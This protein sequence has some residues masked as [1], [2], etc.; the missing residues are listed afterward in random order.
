[1]MMG[2]NHDSLLGIS[3]QIGG[4]AVIVT[5]GGHCEFVEYAGTKPAPAADACVKLAIPC[6]YVLGRDQE[7]GFLFPERPDVIE[8]MSQFLGRE[9]LQPAGLL[10]DRD[11]RH[12]HHHSHHWWRH[13]HHHH[14]HGHDDHR[15]DG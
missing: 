9:V 6:T 4:C 15:R 1:M 11:P 7:H 14:H 2:G 13:H 10:P 5:A 3:G 12:H 8:R